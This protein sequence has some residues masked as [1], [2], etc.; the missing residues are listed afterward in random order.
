MS[1]ADAGQARGCS[2]WPG[3]DCYHPPRAGERCPRDKTAAETNRLTVAG[4]VLDV[5]VLWHQLVGILAP[6]ETFGRPAITLALMVGMRLAL[7][8]EELARVLLAQIDRLLARENRTTPEQAEVLI[9]E[10]AD[11]ILERAEVD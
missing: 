7:E 8:H 5:D 3:C 2:E 6:N 11:A 4:R 1:T 9:R 10:L